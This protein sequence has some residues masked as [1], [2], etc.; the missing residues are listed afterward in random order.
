LGCAVGGNGGNGDDILNVGEDFIA[1]EFGTT[2]KK[3]DVYVTTGSDYETETIDGEYCED[4][5]C[6]STATCSLGY[7]LTGCTTF[8]DDSLATLSQTSNS[9]FSVA[10]INFC[11]SDKFN[12]N[13]NFCDDWCNT[14][15]IWPCGN[16]RL[17]G[18]TEGNTDNVDYTCSCA[19]CNG[20][21]GV[22]G[23]PSRATCI[24]GT[25]TGANPSIHP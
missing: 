17:D 6:S 19:G 24:K 16:N 12:T 3:I 5:D 21:P 15:G 23:T 4:E 14:D 25:L 9:C 10:N 18:I 8:G 7:E 22:R 2:V 20:C 11:S 13:I 1:Q